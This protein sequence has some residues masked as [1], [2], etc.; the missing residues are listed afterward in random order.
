MPQFTKRSVGC[1]LASPCPLGLPGPHSTG[2]PDLHSTGPQDLCSTG[3]LPCR[4]VRLPPHR[5]TRPRILRP[6]GLPLCQGPIPQASQNYSP[7]GPYPAGMR[8]PCSTGPLDLRSTGSPPHKHTRPHATGL[9]RLHSTGLQD[10]PSTRPPHNRTT[11][12]LLHQASILQACQA[13]PHRPAELLLHQGPTRMPARSHYT[14]SLGHRS[15]RPPS[16]RPTRPL[17]PRW[18]PCRPARPLPCKVSSLQAC[19]PPTLQ[20]C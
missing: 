18:Q 14:G 19:Q 1:C 7:L 13:S 17:P 8:S 10:C 4:P 6:S 20:A 11:G 3:P 5:T 9:S 2:P 12:L 15:A 16:G